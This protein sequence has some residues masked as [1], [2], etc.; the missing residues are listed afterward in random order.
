M[1]GRVAATVARLFG[2]VADAVYGQSLRDPAPPTIYMPLAQ[3]A[4]LA[5]PNA[6]FRISLRA[7]NDLAGQMPTLAEALRA[8][9]KGITFTLSRLEQDLDA[10]IAQERLVA[11]LA[12]FF[13]AIALL[14]SGVGLYGVSSY[15]ATRRRAEIG[16]RL[17]LGGQPQVVLRGMLKRTALFVFGG[18]VLGLLV[19]LWLSRFVAPLLYGL[20][21]H[22]PVTLLA[23][24]LILGSVA[25]VAGWIP[26]SRA[27]RIDPAQV[28]REN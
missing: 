2:I 23:S 1:L 15:A 25:A 24:T 17:A 16:I 8:V 22:D 14:L 6:P 5:P 28:L 19:S 20:E 11:M 7:A 3:S 27:T 12:G 26:A 21:A 13:G 4:G 10:S 18:T 9:D